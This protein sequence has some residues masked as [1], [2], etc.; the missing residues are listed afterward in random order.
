MADS[1]PSIDMPSD[2]DIWVDSV[3]KKKG[4]IFGLGSISKLTLITF[5]SQ[6]MKHFVKSGGC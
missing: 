6:P 1:Q 5:S 2:L 4:K 3:G